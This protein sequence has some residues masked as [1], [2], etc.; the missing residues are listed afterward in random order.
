MKW[1]ILIGLLALVGCTND[2][3]LPP[4]TTEDCVC[5][6]VNN[7]TKLLNTTWTLITE[8]YFIVP[9]GFD[10]HDFDSMRDYGINGYNHV[11]NYTLL[12]AY[13]EGECMIN[14]SNKSIC[15]TRK[16]I[17]EF[18]IDKSKIEFF[19]VNH[20]GVEPVVSV[21]LDEPNERIY[22][23]FSGTVDLYNRKEDYID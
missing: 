16:A 23:R 18:P 2:K 1:I 8:P 20:Y 10:R 21:I 5:D 9:V 17:C 22:L 3:A 15:E 19:T 14:C 7:K 12:K 13:T 6:Y 11:V 4:S